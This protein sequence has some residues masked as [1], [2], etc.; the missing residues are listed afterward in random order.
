MTF[1][2]LKGTGDGTTREAFYH[3]QA[4]R[5]Y[6]TVNAEMTATVATGNLYLDVFNEWGQNLAGTVVTVPAGATLRGST[7]VMVSHGCSLILRVT[8]DERVGGYHVWLTGS[9]AR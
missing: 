2:T 3:F 8:T 6:V 7:R 4:D 9:V 1:N 5:G